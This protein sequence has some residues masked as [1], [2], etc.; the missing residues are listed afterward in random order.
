MHAKPET[1]YHWPWIALGVD[2]MTLNAGKVYGPKQTGALYIKTGVN[3]APL[4]VGGGQERGMRSGTEN[5]A[6]IIGFATALMQAQEL[7]NEER[8]RLCRTKSSLF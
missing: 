6:N 5:V 7:R 1:I 4:I 2:M 8:Q 3:I